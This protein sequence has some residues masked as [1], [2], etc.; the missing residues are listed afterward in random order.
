M[1]ALKLD[2]VSIWVQ[3]HLILV[4]YLNRGVAEDLCE[5]IGVVDRSANDTEVDRGNF[6]Q[7]RVRVDISMPLC[8]GRVLS[9]EDGKECWVSFK[10]EHFPNIC[11]WCGCLDHSDRDCAKWIE[12]DGT[13]DSKERVYGPW[14]WAA[15]TQVRRKPVVVVPGFYEARKKGGLK[16]N[17]LVTEI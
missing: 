4:S 6:F 1:H 13:L 9:M 16:S 3:V 12:G 14:I 8:R 2:S 15:P 17:T 10:Y 7:I 5:A 11:Y